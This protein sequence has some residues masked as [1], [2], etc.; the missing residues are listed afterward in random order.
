MAKGFFN[1]IENAE[2][3][4]GLVEDVCDAMVDYQVCAAINLS[5]LRLILLQTALQQDVYNKSFLLIVSLTPSP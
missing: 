1:N 5:F 3:L 4:A 2:K